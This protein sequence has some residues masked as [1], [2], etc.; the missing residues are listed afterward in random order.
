MT[1]ELTAVATF[2]WYTEAVVSDRL[3]PVSTFGWYL[4]DIIPGVPGDPEI[5]TFALFLAQIKRIE[6]EL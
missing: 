6:L 1:T 5:V 3:T 4:T 2:G